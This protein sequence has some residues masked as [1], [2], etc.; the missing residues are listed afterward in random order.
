MLGTRCW[1][2][3]S[4]QGRRHSWNTFFGK[5]HISIL[6]SA[7]HE[8]CLFVAVVFRTCMADRHIVDTMCQGW[9]LDVKAVH[10]DCTSWPSLCQPRKKNSRKTHPRKNA[11]QTLCYIVVAAV[12]TA[13]GPT[14]CCLYESS[15]PSGIQ[16]NG[17]LSCQK[18]WNVCANNAWTSSARQDGQLSQNMPTHVLLLHR[19]VAHMFDKCRIGSRQ[20]TTSSGKH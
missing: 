9:R 16:R 7:W 11:T 3:L 15:S 10:T 18:A 14:S 5:S 1:W 2:C 12:P 19:S 8:V 13:L 6:A 4:L 20:S 17:L